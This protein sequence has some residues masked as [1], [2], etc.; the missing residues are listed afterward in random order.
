MAGAL[1]KSEKSSTGPGIHTRTQTG[2]HPFTCL[3]NVSLKLVYSRS[4][5]SAHKPP[6]DYFLL[7]ILCDTKCSKI[8]P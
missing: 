6:K 4:R 8:L 2:K 7:K 5:C 3:G 1:E